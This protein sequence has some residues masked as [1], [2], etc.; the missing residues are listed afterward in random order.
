MFALSSDSLFLSLYFRISLAEPDSA[1]RGNVLHTFRDWVVKIHGGSKNEVYINLTCA[2]N[3]AF[4]TSSLEAGRHRLNTTIV[5]FFIKVKSDL[6]R[7]ACPHFRH[8]SNRHS[9]RVPG[10]NGWR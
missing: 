1:S 3:L 2:G 4:Y 7:R 10:L 9:R 6:T 5:Q 8:H